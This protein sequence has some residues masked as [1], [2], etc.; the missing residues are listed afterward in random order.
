MSVETPELRNGNEAAGPEQTRNGPSFRPNVDILELSDE[1]VARA[2]LPGADG[3]SIDIDFEDGVLS[4][5]GRVPE[6]QGE[7]QQYLLNEYRVG[8]FYRTFQISEDIDVER[9]SAE[10]A[11]GVLTLHMPKVEEAR[12][13]KIKVSSR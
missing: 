4:I 12:P 3:D 10:F 6:R 5:Y 2:D 13:R 1:L 8:D 9:I 11:D 7:N